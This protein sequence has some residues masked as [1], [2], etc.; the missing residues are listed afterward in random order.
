MASY[1]SDLHCHTT[2][3]AYNRLYPDTWHEDHFPIYPIQGNFTQLAKGKARV[4]MLSL[5]PIEQG[6]VTARP[7]GLGSGNITDFLARLIVD[8]PKKRADEIQDFNHDYYDDLIKE[9]TF[10]QNS[11]FPVTHKVSVNPF[12]KRTFN[13]RIAGNFSDLTSLLELDGD[14]NPGAAAKN[15]IAVVLTIEGAHSLGVGQKN[16]LSKD[17]AILKIKLEQNI[18]KLKNLGPLGREGAWCPF[19]ITLSHHFWNQLGGHS[20]SLWNTIRKVMD[21]NLGINE[22][23]TGLGKFVVD[24]LLDNKEGKKRILIDSAHMCYRVRKWYFSY[25]ASRGDNI[26]VFYSHIA[27]NGKATMD[28]AQMHGD[29]DNIHEVADKLYEA[30]TEFNPWDGQVSDEEIMIVHNSKGLIGLIL[31]ERIMMGKETLDATKKL[32]RFKSKK[33]KRRL[34]IQPFIKQILH[35][36]RHIYDVTGIADGIW[37]NICLGTDYNGMI[38]PIKSFNT[39]EKLPVLQRTLFSE[40]KKLTATEPILLGKPDSE[41][42]EIVDKI[43]WRNN[44][45]FLEQNFC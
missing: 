16:T 39:S 31:D 34:W 7:L 43:F 30:S 22:D 42:Q 36:A 13:Y 41:V 19:F 35:I 17:P 10:L 11:A 18:N 32:A 26:P 33:E 37:D 40:L 23:I 29:P 15:T 38:T 28:E 3:F 8:I 2:L 24:Q 25:L 45:L 1:F 44:L 6:F 9:L 27:V 21:Q 4:I 20:V 5:Y 12:W 14:M